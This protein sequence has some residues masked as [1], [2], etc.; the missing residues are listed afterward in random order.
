MNRRQ[1]RAQEAQSRQ[2]GAG[3]FGR[4]IAASAAGALKR[5][6]LHRICIEHDDWCGIFQGRGCTCTPDIRCHNADGT[7]DTI[8]PD[9]SVARAGRLNRQT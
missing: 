2:Q 1:R 3:Y 5:P 4:L 8:E 9:G 6:G 7:I